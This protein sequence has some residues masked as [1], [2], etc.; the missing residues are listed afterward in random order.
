MENRLEIIIGNS[1]THVLMRLPPL[2]HRYPETQEYGDGHWV[3][4]EVEVVVG[5]FRGHFEASFET[6][7]FASFCQHLRRMHETVQG[8]AKFE[9]IEEQ[10]AITLTANSRGQI[11]IAGSAKDVVGTGNVL[12]FHFAIDQTYLPPIIASLDKV[13]EYFPAP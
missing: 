8:V 2:S 5:G 4:T 9:T 13:C 7:D 11:Q 3:S 1:T 10:L 12:T 6:R